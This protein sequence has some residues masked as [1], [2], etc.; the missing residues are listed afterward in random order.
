MEDDLLKKF[1]NYLAVEKGLARNTLD[2]YERDLRKYREAMA[3]RRPDDITQADVVGFLSGLAAAGIATP[4]ISRCLAAIG[5][6]QVP[7]DRWAS[8]EDHRDLETPR[9][10]KRLPKTLSAMVQTR[11]SAS[12][13]LQPLSD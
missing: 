13:T 7:S 6:L 9:G 12:L 3:A 4:S 11:C 2:S 5:V 10:W 1:L 8:E